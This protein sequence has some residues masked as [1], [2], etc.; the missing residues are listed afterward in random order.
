MNF[1]PYSFREVNEK[2]EENKEILSSDYD[3]VL[4][5]ETKSPETDV[6]EGNKKEKKS[7]FREIQ[8]PLHEENQENCQLQRE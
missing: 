5:D 1:P 4:K 2:L 7:H 6:F 3:I 8:L